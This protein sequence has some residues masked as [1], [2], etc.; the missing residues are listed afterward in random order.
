MRFL[1]W[2]CF[3]AALGA[4]SLEIS[5]AASTHQGIGLFLVR[6]ESP[7]GQEPS[8]V[9]WD[10]SVPAVMAIEPRDIFAG[11]VAASAEKTIACS[12]GKAPAGAAT[13]RCIVYGGRNGIRN[14]PVAVVK[15]EIVKRA[16]KGK[17]AVHIG[18]ALAA[19]ADLKKIAIPDAEGEI[20]LH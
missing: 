13:Y 4:Q 3:P 6:L 12:K 1:I 8:T 19:T 15:Y 5:P 11:S 17:L 18:N 10:L 14:G 16:A 9:Q 7:A 2:L 20:I